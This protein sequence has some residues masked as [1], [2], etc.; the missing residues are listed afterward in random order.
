MS[1]SQLVTIKGTRDGL[2]L[3]LN[4]QCSFKSIVNELEQKLSMNG[5]DHDEPMI[6]VTI[7]LGKRYLSNQQQEALREVIRE[8][9]NLVVESIDSE[10]ITK[11]EALAWK[12]DTEITPVVRTIRSGQVVETRGDMLL[13]GD[14]NPGGEVL[15]T[16][17]IFIMGS[18]R[19]MAHAGIHGD[20]KAIVAAS[21]MKPNQLRIAD[22]LSQAPN[23][24]SEGVYMS[25]GF[26][27]AGEGDIR[28][29]PLHEV[30]RRRPDLASFE[31]RM[32]NG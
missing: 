18:M 16:G 27:D 13:I 5:L 31:R 32:L 25:C 2:T 3:H 17:N 15:A 29:A 23:Y 8:R 30:T 4:D 21:Y 1:N 24:E 22:Q 10:V 20:N 12:E 9:Q 19:G 14:V 7:Q 26:I 6:R 11:E 28:I